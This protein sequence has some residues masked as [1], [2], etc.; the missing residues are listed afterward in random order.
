[1]VEDCR[2]ER[3]GRNGRALVG[4]GFALVV[5]A[6]Q[7]L[8]LARAHE[9]Q[10]DGQE[11]V[12]GQRA[13][14]VGF[15]RRQRVWVLREHPEDQAGREEEGCSQRGHHACRRLRVD[16]EVLGGRSVEVR[17]RGVVVG[18]TYVHGGWIGMV[19]VFLELCAGWLC[20]CSDGI[21]RL[22]DRRLA[23]CNQALDTR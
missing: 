18:C 9:Q 10:E 22:K 8:E 6:V 12:H 20:V 21:D 2:D 7:A 5:V 16:A 3:D 14:D 4:Q 15:K 17:D 23:T 11:D 1:M 13:A 19:V